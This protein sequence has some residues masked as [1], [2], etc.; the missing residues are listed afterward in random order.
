MK[1][2]DIASKRE[3]GVIC[4]F[5]EETDL[6]ITARATKQNRIEPFLERDVVCVDYRGGN[7]YIEI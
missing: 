2:K 7:V 3:S 6:D 1:V 4:V 5:N